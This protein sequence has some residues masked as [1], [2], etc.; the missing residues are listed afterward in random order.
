MI[1]ALTS[2]LDNLKFYDIADIAFCVI[3]TENNKLHA[4]V[5]TDKIRLARFVYLRTGKLGGILVGCRDLKGLRVPGIKTCL[6]EHIGAACIILAAVLTGSA[7]LC[8]AG[9]CLAG[10][11]Y[12][13]CPT[14]SSAFTSEVFGPKHFAVNFSI[15]NCNLIFASFI[16]TGASLIFSATGGYGTSFIL[17]LGLSIIALFINIRLED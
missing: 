6:L 9:L 14:I 12:G 10:L 7:V 2:L 3:V 13:T 11:S 4:G 5:G 17:L 16:A 15:M 1:F 8:V